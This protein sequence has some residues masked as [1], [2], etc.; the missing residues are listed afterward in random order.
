MMTTY[1]VRVGPNCNLGEGNLHWS[2]QSHPAEG[3]GKI[4]GSWSVTRAALDIGLFTTP[5]FM[6]GFSIKAKSTALMT[7][8]AGIQTASVIHSSDSS[9]SPGLNNLNRGR[10][11]KEMIVRW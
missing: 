8:T 7:R 5:K 6:E 9:G 2:S 11:T 3:W 4:T 10:V 1:S